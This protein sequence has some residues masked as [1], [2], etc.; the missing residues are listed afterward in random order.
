MRVFVINAYAD[1]KDKYLSDSRYELYPA[2]LWENVSDDDIDDYYF[3]HNAKKEYRKKVIACSK[4]HKQLLLKIIIEDLKNVLIMEDHAIIED[5]KELELLEEEGLTDFCYVGGQMN[6]PLMKDFK[7][8][9]KDDI[10]YNFSKGV[11]PIDPK[12]ER[13]DQTCG[14]FIPNAKVAQKLLSL[15]P[16]GKKARAIDTEY[17][18]L[19]KKKYISLFYY[20]AIVKLYLPDAKKD[21]T[22]SQY[23][24]IDDQSFY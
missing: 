18:A 9:P 10:Q 11:N 22:Y 5:W 2:I 3:R 16:N 19:Q 14:Y 6:A 7:T 24:L 15:I 4:S 23:K 20:P 8:F 21:F 17:I 1:R 13:I 12:E